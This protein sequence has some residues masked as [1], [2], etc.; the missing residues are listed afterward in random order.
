MGYVFR[1]PTECRLSRADTPWQCVVELHFLTDKNGQNLG[2]QRNEL[3]GDTIF[4]KSEVEERIRRAQRAILNP[5]KAAWN[6]LGD[7]DDALLHKNS[8]MMW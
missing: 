3:F 5:S 1:C 6:F 4:E 7:D 8:P 2:Q